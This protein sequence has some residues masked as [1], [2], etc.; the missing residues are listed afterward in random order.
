MRF[1]LE[2]FW[3]LARQSS[4]REINYPTDPAKVVSKIVTVPA[5]SETGVHTHA[6]PLYGY[7]LEG[8]ITIDYGSEHGIKT[9]GEGDALMEAIQFP[10]NGKNIGDETVKILVVSF[11]SAEN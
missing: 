11:G 3:K 5:G 10:H 2:L 9:F 6:E 4:D 7:I 8:E 1:L